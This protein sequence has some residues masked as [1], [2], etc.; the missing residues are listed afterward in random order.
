MG[1]SCS[2]SPL[3][4]PNLQLRNIHAIKRSDILH[5]FPLNE[6][7]IVVLL[8]FQL[9]RKIIILLLLLLL[10]LSLPPL[11]RFSSVLATFPDFF[12]LYP[13]CSCRDREVRPHQHIVPFDIHH[14]NPNKI[15]FKLGPGGLH[16][17]PG[18]Y[19][20]DSEGSLRGE[21][22]STTRQHQ[23]CERKNTK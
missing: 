17:L 10:V 13:L 22:A 7:K 5:H 14:I 18:V 3:L 15:S 11:P 8:R 9:V 6:L 21:L 23:H 20:D 12:A 1:H 4:V 16:S 19:V 2:V